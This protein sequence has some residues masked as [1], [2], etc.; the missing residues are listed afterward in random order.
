MLAHGLDLVE[1][2]RIKKAVDSWGE[3]FLQRVYTPAELELFRDRPSQLAS[4]FAGKEAVMK[5]LGGGISWKEIEILSNERG[6]PKV[7]LYSR[8]EARRRELGIKELVI[9]LSHSREHAAASVIG[10]E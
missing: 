3:R 8:A 9:S 5:A 10:K 7:L 6:E 2:S 4:R 1:I